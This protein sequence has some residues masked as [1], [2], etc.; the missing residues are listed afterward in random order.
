MAVIL[1]L[2]GLFLM[3]ESIAM[4]NMMRGGTSMLCRIKYLLAALA[5]LYS[6]IQACRLDT[7]WYTLALTVALALFVFDR[8]QSRYRICRRLNALIRS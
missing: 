8:A 6:M 7:C 4:L 5:G 3:L 2:P 1:F